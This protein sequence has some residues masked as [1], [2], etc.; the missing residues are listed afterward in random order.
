MNPTPV[1][2]TVFAAGLVRT[3]LIVLVPPRAIVLG[4]ND[5]VRVGGATTIKVA[6]EAVPSPALAEVGITLFG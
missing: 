5:F 2:A 3:K 1:S 4:V 6:V